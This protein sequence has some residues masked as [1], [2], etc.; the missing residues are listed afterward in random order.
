MSQA[1]GTTPRPRAVH[2]AAAVLL[3]LLLVAGALTWAAWVDLHDLGFCDALSY[4]RVHMN[5]NGRARFTQDLARALREADVLG[6]SPFE[7]AQLPFFVEHSVAREGTPTP[8]AEPALTSFR[9]DPTRLAVPLPGLSVWSNRGGRIAGVGPVSPL[10]VFE[11]GLPLSRDPWGVV[12]PEPG[13]AFHQGHMLLVKPRD[14]A[15]LAAPEGHFTLGLSE[16]IPVTSGG[17]HGWWAYPGTTLVV[18]VEGD[19]VGGREADVGVVLEPLG[20]GEGQPV[21]AVRG[22]PLALQPQDG[23]LAA[24]THL[25]VSGDPWEIRIAVPPRRP[26]GPGPLAA[27]RLP[28]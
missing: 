10:V 25:A 12:D 24:G 28:G 13:T 23:Y 19:P 17:D 4:D 22:A 16:E 9:L 2:L 1:E 18:R 15:H 14:P 8:L 21:V 20:A 5:A 11:D 3:P 7:S 27:P 6:S 26:H